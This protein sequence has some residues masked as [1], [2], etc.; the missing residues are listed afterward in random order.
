MRNLHDEKQRMSSG[1]S[2]LPGYN[3]VVYPKHIE[4]KRKFVNSIDWGG[5]L[6][7]LDA[8]LSDGPRRKSGLRDRGNTEL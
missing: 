8:L 7:H 6:V 2:L 1:G 3:L 5:I 4:R